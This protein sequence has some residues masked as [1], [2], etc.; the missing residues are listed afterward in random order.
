M[1]WAQRRALRP[2]LAGRP[3]QV[4]G[5]YLSEPG[6]GGR[7]DKNGAFVERWQRSASAASRPAP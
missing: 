6:P 5:L 2:D 3:V 7:L 1:Q 4:M